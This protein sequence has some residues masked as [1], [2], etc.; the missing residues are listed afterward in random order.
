MP[1][2][3]NLVD[4]PWR[5]ISMP[6]LILRTRLRFANSPELIRSLRAFI[7]PPQAEIL[8]L[9]TDGPGTWERGAVIRFASADSIAEI[10]AKHTDILDQFE[11]W[12]L[13]QRERYSPGALEKDSHSS[14]AEFVEEGDKF[15][16]CFLRADPSNA[17]HTRAVDVISTDHEYD[18]QS[19]KPQGR[20]KT[21]WFDDGYVVTHYGNKEAKSSA[22][23]FQKQLRTLNGWAI[24]DHQGNS[25]GCH[26]GTS[27]L[28]LPFAP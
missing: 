23:D 24:L 3:D 13:Y 8:R 18:P 26:P 12:S 6:L 9:D 4:V 16:H 7:H 25:T 2:T 20:K 22:T 17:A 21:H 11:H 5:S 10:Q 27:R 19:K 28:W 1:M 15:F 14:Y